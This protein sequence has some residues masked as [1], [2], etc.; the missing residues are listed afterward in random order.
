MEE[1]EKVMPSTV[2]AARLWYE[3][4]R[5]NRKIKHA[6]LNSAQSTCTFLPMYRKT[7][8]PLKTWVCKVQDAHSIQE[9]VII[10]ES[11]DAFIPRRELKRVV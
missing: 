9:E 7:T 11:K 10:L 6:A 5:H 2:K 3:Y 1:A 8:R 4:F